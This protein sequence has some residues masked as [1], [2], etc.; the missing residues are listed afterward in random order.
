MADIASRLKAVQEGIE[1]LAE[2]A[3]P[4]QADAA[5]RLVQKLKGELDDA[6]AEASGG[7]QEP[8]TSANLPRSP[9][10]VEIRCPIC[11]LRSFTYQKGTMRRSDETESGFEALYHCLSCGHEAWHEA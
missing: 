3:A 8:S 5:S 2:L 6:I 7:P 1:R 9:R 11:S 4:D 10:H